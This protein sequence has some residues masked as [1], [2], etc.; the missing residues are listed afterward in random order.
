MTN[1][2]DDGKYHRMFIDGEF[3]DARS[4]ESVDVENPANE[5]VIYSVPNGGVADAV[6]ALESA[7]RAKAQWAATPAVERGQ[8]LSR[9]AGLISKNRERLA[10]IL[11]R[12]MGKTYT[13]A[14]GE[15]D[16]SADFINFPAQSARRIEGDILPSD[17]P[18]EHIQ[19]HKVP[20]GVT[21][22]IAAWNFPLALAC[23]KIG[24]ALTT[25]NVMVVKPPTVTPVAV[26]CLGELALEAGV[27]PGVLNLVAGG[28]STLGEELVT[29]PLTKL[30]SMTGSTST[31]QQIFRKAAE[32]L[33]AVRLELGG[34]APFILLADG[35]V[36]K[37]VE[38]AVVSRHLNS[39]QVCTCPERFYIEDAV[40]DEFVEKYSARVGALRLGDPMKPTTD[41]GPKVNAAE[42]QRLEQMVDDAV[43]AGARVAIGG[44][45]PS[46]AEFERGHWYEPTVLT[47]CTHE[48]AVMRDEV[49][50]VVSPFMRVSGF[51]EALALANDSD[52]GLAAFLFTKDLVKVQRAVAELEFGEIYVNRPM[53]E[54]RQ[55][56][57]NGHKL[58]GIGGEDGR[59]G[60]DNYLEK[61]TMYVNF[62]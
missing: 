24:P 26:L 54:Q 56:F 7:D 30:I 62:G 53:G 44:K 34:K 43:A 48:M 61:K 19:I 41:I 23:R 47:E 21:V 22:G 29:N 40:Y 51:E 3:V 55:G 59:Y 57:H 60:M 38:A 17:L 27:P 50:G 6:A 4:G 9:L 20:Y 33:T 15:V 52:F 5:E 16:V 49:F 58:S 12:E 11:V 42:T 14:L 2:S 25:G 18:N 35:H 32:R 31:G 8:I 1:F 39:G 28:G 13:L 10:K 45:R 37:A 36:D 46:G